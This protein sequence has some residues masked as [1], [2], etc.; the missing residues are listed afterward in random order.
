MKPTKR[1]TTLV[2]AYASLLGNLSA[3]DRA[4]LVSRLSKT[5]EIS[6]RKKKATFREAFGAFISEKSAEEIIE[7]IRSSRISNRQNEPL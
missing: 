4:A 7:D 5:G 3:D 6:T 1:N 2:D